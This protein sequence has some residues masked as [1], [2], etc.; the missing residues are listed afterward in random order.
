[1]KKLAG[2]F[3]TSIHNNS[4]AR[5]SIYSL[6]AFKVQQK[7][8]QKTT[9][10]HD[11]LDYAYWNNRGWLDSSCEYYTTHKA[12]PAKVKLARAAGSIVSLF[13]V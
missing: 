12:N 3:F 6:I 9:K 10:C 7:Y 1:M 8:W 11:T 13:F 2:S 4:A 5:P